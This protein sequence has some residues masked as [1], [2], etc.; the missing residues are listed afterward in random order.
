MFSMEDAIAS[1]LKGRELMNT[2]KTSRG[3][4]NCGWNV[5]P[6]G[7]QL[8]HIDPSTKYRT[9]SGKLLNPG[10][11]RSM[12]QSVVIAEMM[13]CRVLCACCHAI[14][15]YEDDHYLLGRKVSV[16]SDKVDVC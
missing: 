12:K 8:D 2:W 7:L 4:E 13:K 16:V 9:K 10:E 11:M 3:C 15:S 5:H 14:R 1:G 6:A